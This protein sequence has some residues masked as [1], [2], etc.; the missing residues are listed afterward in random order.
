MA[1][2]PAGAA[3][4]QTAP[5]QR[6]AGK[7]TQAPPPCQHRRTS[8]RARGSPLRRPFRLRAARQA[9]RMRRR[10]ALRLTRY[11]ARTFETWNFAV[12]EVMWSR[13][14][15]SLLEKFSSSSS[16]TSPLPPGELCVGHDDVVELPIHL[17]PPRTENRA[18]Q[19]HVLAPG[20]LRME[21]GPELE[22]APDAAAATLSAIPAI[23]H[24][25][26]APS[27]ES[28]RPQGREGSPRVP[29]RRT[30]RR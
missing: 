1:P 27:S 28:P 14:A 26:S 18:V 20:E 10:S 29:S 5:S 2:R 16:R 17:A 9:R 15:I 3:Q 6:R 22:E 19:V 11:L 21:S 25:V 8:T 30:N 12:R 13:P 24:I 4:G 7:N 23:P